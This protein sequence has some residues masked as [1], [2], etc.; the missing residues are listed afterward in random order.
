MLRNRLTVIVA[1]LGQPAPSH[2]LSPSE[3]FRKPALAHQVSWRVCVWLLLCARLQMAAPVADLGAGVLGMFAVLT[4]RCTFESVHEINEA[5]DDEAANALQSHS[6][7]V[8]TV[9][10]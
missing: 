9:E 5:V 10:K 2:Q 8:K 1:C 4:G 6:T 7:R 3:S